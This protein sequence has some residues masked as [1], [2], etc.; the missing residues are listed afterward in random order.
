MTSSIKN[1]TFGTD[2]IRARAGLFPMDAQTIRR[3]AQASCCLLSETNKTVILGRDT[4]ASGEWITQSL[5][6]GFITGGAEVLDGGIMPTAAVACAIIEEQAAL[7]IVITASHNPA[8][9]NGLKFFA[10]NG[11][12]LDDDEQQ[13]ISLAYTD[14]PVANNGSSRP[15]ENPLIGW[16]RRM[17]KIDLQGLKIMLDCAHGAA[18]YAAP[19]VLR[20][21]G[22]SVV[23]RGCAPNGRNINDQVGALHPPQDL[24][25]CQLGIC[26]DGDADRVVLICQQRGVLDGD[27]ILYLL[28]D[29]CSTPMVSTIMAIS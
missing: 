14:P 5:I 28:K 18:A 22:A 4:R 15:L 20:K 12:K 16:Q 26:L 25:D 19:P 23:L 27:D 2:G 10:A 21:L 24:V 1:P 3:I 8:H 29:S 13:R 11:K 17:P 7:G 6:D 9:D